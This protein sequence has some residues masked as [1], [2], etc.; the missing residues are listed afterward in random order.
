MSFFSSMVGSAIGAGLAAAA[1]EMLEKQGGVKG[2]VDKF[3]QA[4]Y[5]E[6]VRSWVG[7]GP[8]LPISADEVHQALGSDTVKAF[9]EKLGISPEELT[10]KLSEFL[11]AA[12]DKA[13]PNGTLPAES[14]KED[15][16]KE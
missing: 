3:E 10:A 11:P 5:G 12:V 16:G 15:T 8:N 1:G 14:E 2:L 4:G 6:K 7:N 9:A 13:T